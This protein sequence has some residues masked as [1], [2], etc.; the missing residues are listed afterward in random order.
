MN[1]VLF[2]MPLQMGSFLFEIY[3]SDIDKNQNTEN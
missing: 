1:Q 3:K 2:L